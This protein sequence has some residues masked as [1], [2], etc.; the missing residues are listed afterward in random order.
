MSVRT[1]I[2]AALISSAIGCGGIT[3]VDYQPY[4]CNGKTCAADEACVTRHYLMIYIMVPH[5]EKESRCEKRASLGVNSAEPYFVKLPD[6]TV[7]SRS[8]Y[9]AL[10]DNQKAK[11]LDGTLRDPDKIWMQLIGK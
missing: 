6:G 4:N 8:A 1:L 3:N 2:S 7:I 11:N 9:I 10:P 5:Y